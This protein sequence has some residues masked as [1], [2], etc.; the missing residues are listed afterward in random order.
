MKLA[1][2][3][4]RHMTHYAQPTDDGTHRHMGHIADTPSS[5]SAGV[6]AP[7]AHGSEKP[8]ICGSCSAVRPLRSCS[9]VLASRTLLLSSV[10]LLA[11]AQSEVAF[12]HR[13]NKQ[14][15]CVA[16]LRLPVGP[17]RD[18]AVSVAA[19][20]TVVPSA[21]LRT[22][23]AAC[24]VSAA[25][26][27]LQAVAFAPFPASLLQ[28]G[29]ADRVHSPPSAQLNE[30]DLHLWQ[31]ELLRG[32]ATLIDATWHMNLSINWRTP[33]PLSGNYKVQTVIL[34]MQ[35]PIGPLQLHAVLCSIVIRHAQHDR[36]VRANSDTRQAGQ[37]QGQTLAH[38]VASHM[39]SSYPLQEN[40]SDTVLTY[41]C[42][43]HHYQLVSQHCARLTCRHSR[44]QVCSS[45]QGNT[46]RRQVMSRICQ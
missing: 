15:W 14:Q 7:V 41:I 5:S 18:A 35:L 32:P 10:Q 9:A 43:V 1:K 17:S 34:T 2:L 44:G 36:Q 28:L 16:E 8:A 19:G 39:C 38:S 22:A 13:R 42:W 46:T 6:A 12:C 25:K 4:Y 40:S 21:G 23:A 3:Q 33:H 24:G 31:R 27:Y 37:S 30:L 26:R 45:V 29:R 20:R 11:V